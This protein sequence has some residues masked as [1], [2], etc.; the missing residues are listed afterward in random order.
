MKFLGAILVFAMLSGRSFADEQAAR[1]M[2]EPTAL[3]NAVARAFQQGVESKQASYFQEVIEKTNRLWELGIATPQLCR[4]RAQ[5]HTILGEPAQAIRAYREGLQI[6]PTNER[7]WQELQEV[8]S[9]LGIPASSPVWDQSILGPLLSAFSVQWC[10]VGLA[11][12]GWLCLGRWFVKRAPLLFWIGVIGIGTGWV[13]WGIVKYEQ[14]QFK[15]MATQSRVIVQE[16]IRP[17]LGNSFEYPPVSETRFAVG[18]E[19]IVLHNRGNWVQ[20]QNREG[21]IGWI[22]SRAGLEVRKVRHQD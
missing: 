2:E 13:G 12:L 11:A 15:K 8:Q 4:I 1:Q 9:G 16:E 7:L 20:C 22:P 5:A 19:L 18:E 6:D 10:A 14:L 3:A 21:I 17:R